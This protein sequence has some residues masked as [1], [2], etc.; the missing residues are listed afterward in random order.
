MQKSP[1]NIVLYS[2]KFLTIPI[3][4]FALYIQSM[5]EDSPGG[6]FQSGI[7]I[8]LLFILQDMLVK[9]GGS[10]LIKTFTYRVLFAISSIGALI[11]IGIGLYPLFI[12][13]DF[14]DYGTSQRLGIFLVEIGIA[15]VIFS[16]MCVI[17]KIFSHSFH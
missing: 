14:L 1:S 17:Y 4:G 16:S 6:G 5:G 3:I 11:Y 8:A 15:L 2:L 9:H 13:G 10:I 7:M 12:T